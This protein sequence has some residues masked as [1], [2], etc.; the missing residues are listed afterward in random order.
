MNE[1]VHSEW[2]L[3]KRVPVGIIAALTLQAVVGFWYLGVFEQRVA[4]IEAT[5][6]TQVQGAKVETQVESNA[7]NIDR[8]EARTLKALDDIQESLEEIKD[9]LREQEINTK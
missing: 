9:R 2:H 4:T 8:L 6:F 3:D 1:A 5:R 7:K